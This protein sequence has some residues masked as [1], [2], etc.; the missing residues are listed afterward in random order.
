MMFGKGRAQGLGWSRQ[1]GY[2]TWFGVPYASLPRTFNGLIRTRPAGGA[3]RREAAAARRRRHLNL[4]LDP[5]SRAAVSPSGKIV[6]SAQL[7]AA[8]T[9]RMVACHPALP[10]VRPAA[11]L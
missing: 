1:V 6:A 8:A 2:R 4:A 7:L 5:S 10:L 11:Y 9:P 3:R